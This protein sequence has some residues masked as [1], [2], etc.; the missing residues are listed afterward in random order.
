MLPLRRLPLTKAWN[1]RDLG[2]YAGDGGV[3]AYG[4]VWRSDLLGGLPESDLAAIE[5]AGVRTVIDLRG[6]DECRRVPNDF[7]QRPGV[8]YRSIPLLG[9]IDDLTERTGMPIRDSFLYSLNTLYGAMADSNPAAFVSVFEALDEGLTRGGVLFHCTA[10]KDRTG[11]IAGLLLALLGVHPAD[12]IA[13]Y[14][15]T[16]IYLAAKLAAFPPKDDAV[17]RVVLRS[18]SENMEQFLAHI[19]REYGGAKEFLL[20]FG[21][22]EA[23]IARIRAALLVR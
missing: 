1:L 23:V 11:V 18:Q 4:R 16:E 9:N 8:V 21:L 12:I 22:T 17:A 19:D 15:V 3:T 20:R 13:D 5:A 6:R 10:G 14:A 7:A 2:G